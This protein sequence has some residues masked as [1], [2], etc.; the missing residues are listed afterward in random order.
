[1]L[2]PPKMYLLCSLAVDADPI[3]DLIDKALLYTSRMEARLALATLHVEDA[4]ALTL[5]AD[6]QVSRVFHELVEP[7]QVVE[8]ISF[9]VAEHRWLTLRTLHLILVNFLNF[10]QTVERG[11]LFFLQRI[12]S[13]LENVVHALE[14]WKAR[15]NWRAHLWTVLNSSFSKDT[16]D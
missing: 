9:I 7:S 15:F 13:L 1:M 14:F 2:F 8:H 10:V 5:A 11:K 4:V 3:P 6:A 12:V 16:H